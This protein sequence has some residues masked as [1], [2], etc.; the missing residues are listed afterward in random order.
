MIT[1]DIKVYFK[2]KTIQ[3][4]NNQM[5]PKSNDLLL[6][7]FLNTFYCIKSDHKVDIAWLIWATVFPAAT[8]FSISASEM[9][10]LLPRFKRS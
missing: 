5:F 8:A 3:L 6:F 1:F 2:L 10:E 7:K 4:D 9:A